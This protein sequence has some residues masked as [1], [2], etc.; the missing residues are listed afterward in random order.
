MAA[1]ALQTCLG[2]LEI[3]SQLRRAVHGKGDAS[4]PQCTTKTG[5]QRSSLM[6]KIK[7]SV[8]VEKTQVGSSR[9]NDTPNSVQKT[10]NHNPHTFGD[11]P[12]KNGPTS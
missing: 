7:N 1:D 8:Q 5:I 4:E 10:S 9:E 2:R 11:V 3:Q 12:Q 6:C